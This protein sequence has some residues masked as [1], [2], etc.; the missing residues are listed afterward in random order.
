MIKK[1]KAASEPSF[2]NTLTNAYGVVDNVLELTNN[3]LETTNEALDSVKMS[4]QYGNSIL[5]DITLEQKLETIARLE[6]S[7]LSADKIKEVMESH[8]SR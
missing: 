8:P 4:L 1:S 6:A 2:G 5:F 7:G 3:V